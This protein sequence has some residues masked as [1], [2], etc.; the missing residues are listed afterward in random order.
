M[1]LSIILTW[2]EQ[3]T[4]DRTSQVTNMSLHVCLIASVTLCFKLEVFPTILLSKRV[5]TLK[6]VS[7]H[8][9]VYINHCSNI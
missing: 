3:I 9:K 8:F 4:D 7:K 6:T 1:T 2:S 5:Q